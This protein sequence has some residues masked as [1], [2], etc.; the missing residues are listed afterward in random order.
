MMSSPQAFG[1][2]DVG[3]RRR[4]NEDAF[5]VYP[6]IG[7]YL[8]ADGVGGSAGGERASGLAVQ[9]A[10]EMLRSMLAG[11]KPIFGRF[12]EQLTRDERMLGTALLAANST[13]YAE[14]VIGD[15][16]HGMCT[17]VV[18]ALVRDTRLSIAHVGDSRIYL[19][20]NAVLE[21]LTDDH[22]LVEE[23]Y[24]KGLISRE[25]MATSDLRHIITRVLGADPDVEIELAHR[26]VQA[27]DRLLLCSDGLTNMLSD[28]EIGRILHRSA[29]P[30]DAC[31]Q[32]VAAANESGGVDNITVVTVWW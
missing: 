6:D 4:N 30:D 17:T 18:A 9:A 2:T 25:E 22:S 31:N 21:R 8:V 10:A 27:G 29:T 32:L 12:S 28:A 7:L 23:Q 26:N 3:H 5:G 11:T 16:P 24:R 19:L 1:I 20:R 13:V 15:G 14:G